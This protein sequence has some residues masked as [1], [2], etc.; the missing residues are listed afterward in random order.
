MKTATRIVLHAV[1]MLENNMTV[2]TG[3]VW[4]FKYEQ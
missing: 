3:A 4:E 1:D 2:L